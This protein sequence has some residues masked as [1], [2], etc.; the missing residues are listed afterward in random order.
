VIYPASAQ[1][2]R[3]ND[4]GFHSW[5]DQH[6]DGYF[7]NHQ[8]EPSPSY[9]VLHLASCSHFQP[10]PRSV[11]WTTTYDK[12]CSLSRV[13]LETWAAKTIGGEVTPCRTCFG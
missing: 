10:R 1:P 9:L 2:F 11:N 3:D 5:P 8:R 12:L 13:D 6:P 7:I 4:A